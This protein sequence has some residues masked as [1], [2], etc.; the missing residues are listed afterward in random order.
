MTEPTDQLPRRPRPVRRRT[1]HL[2]RV[3]AGAVLALLA[4]TVGALVT[5][6]PLDAATSGTGVTV[7]ATGPTDT[8][9]LGAPTAGAAPSTGA[10]GSL[11]GGVGASGLDGDVLGTADGSTVPA[12]GTSPETPSADG[13]P[14]SETPVVLH[15]TLQLLAFG[16]QIGMPLLCSLAISSAGP[17]L[18]DPGVSAVVGQILQACVTG[19]NQGADA[20]RSMDAQLSALAAVNPAVGPVLDQLAAELDAAS[21]ADAPF[22][23][24]LIQ[25]STLIRFFRG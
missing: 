9:T 1:R 22:I 2:R 15:P 7:E 17:A 8:L 16:G 11:D 25:I 18:S 19:A 5:N 12:P 10:L 20:L 3:G 6:S 21:T 14:P 24:Y 13:T 4:V 23:T